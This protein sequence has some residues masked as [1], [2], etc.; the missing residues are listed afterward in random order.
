MDLWDWVFV[1]AIVVAIIILFRVILREHKEKKQKLIDSIERLPDFTA[2]ETITS[3]NMSSC[4]AIDK[5]RNKF[6]FAKST[7][8]STH[9]KSYE[10]KDIYSSEVYID[11]Q[12]ITK[13]QRASQIGGVIIGGALLGT[14]GV[15]IGGL[16]GKTQSSQDAV[17]KIDIR[18]VVNDTASPYCEINLSDMVV[19]TNSP[20]YKNLIKQAHHWHSL[21]EVAIKR[22]DR[23]AN[24]E[25]K[26]E[27]SKIA[28]EDS[29]PT[30][31][32]EEYLKPSKHETKVF[33]STSVADELLKFSELRDKGVIT[34][35]EFELQKQK[36]LS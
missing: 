32:T 2:T 29:D 4:L 18:F 23:E 27:P 11:G 3:F 8:T 6:A 24:L 21:L 31:I 25:Q 22:A 9:A 19:K 1:T 30:T 35:D 34:D 20:L 36:L 28:A 26:L 14:A 33:P 7:P 13:T 15:L 17:K 10:Y 16:S 5:T 12:T